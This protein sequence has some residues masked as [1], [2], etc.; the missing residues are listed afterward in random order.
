M[1]AED[2]HIECV[3]SLE[4]LLSKVLQKWALEESFS[5]QVGLVDFLR[6]VETVVVRALAG[7]ALS[8]RYVCLVFRNEF[9]L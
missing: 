2:Q 9:L 5:L 3:F 1:V 6:E 7:G 8:C 4:L